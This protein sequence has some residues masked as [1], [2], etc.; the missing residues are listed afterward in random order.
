MSEVLI[1]GNGGG[2]ETKESIGMAP[3]SS[4]NPTIAS[5]AP[6]LHRIVVIAVFEN[7]CDGRQSQYAQDGS[8]VLVSTD[9]RIRTSKWRSMAQAEPW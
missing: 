2:G 3:T 4:T 8:T 7:R 9:A 5:E 1:S 6:V